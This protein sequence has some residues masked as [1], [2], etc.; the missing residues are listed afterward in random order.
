M[1][2]AKCLVTKSEDSWL[3]HM[4]LSH[5]HFNLINKISSKNLVICLSK[6]IFSK[7]KLCNACQMGMQTSVSFK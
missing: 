1:H 3:W 6:I 7:H 4:R 5:V 2:R